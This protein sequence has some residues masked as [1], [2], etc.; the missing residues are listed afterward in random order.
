MNEIEK[1]NLTLEE[2]VSVSVPGIGE[3]PLTLECKVLY[4]QQQ[5]LSAI[6][7]DILAKYYPVEADTLHPG[8]ERDY[9]IAYYAQI[10]NAYIIED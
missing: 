6:P 9:H 2:P 10:M 8:S 3:F 7:E 4:K 1:L 5:D